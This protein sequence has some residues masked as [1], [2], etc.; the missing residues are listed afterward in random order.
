MC[1]IV[2][3]LFL[4]WVLRDWAAASSGAGVNPRN[5]ASL[6]DLT[7]EVDLVRVSSCAY[8]RRICSPQA[9]GVLC[10]GAIF[11]VRAHLALLPSV[12]MKHTSILVVAA[13]CLVATGMVAQHLLG[14]HFDWP[15]IGD[16][17]ERANGADLIAEVEQE[18]HDDHI[19]LTPQAVDN[20]QLYVAPL[21]RSD[22]QRWLRIPGEIV[23]QPGHS[24]RVLAAPVH[25]IVDRVSALPGMAIGAGDPLFELQVVD[26][27]I[28]DAQIELLDSI[29]RLEI[30]GAELERLA[31]LASSGAVARRQKLDLEYEQKQLAAKRDLR[32]QELMA[33]GL[34]QRDIDEL[35]ATRRFLRKITVR[36]PDIGAHTDAHGL[37]EL[38]RADLHVISDAASAT[39]ESS[40]K[41]H[42]DRWTFTVERLLIAPGQTVDRGDGLCDLAHHSELYIQGQVFEGEVAAVLH[43]AEMQWPLS[44]EFGLAGREFRREDL[45]LRYVANH[46]D[47]ETQTFLFYLPLRN[48]VLNDSTDVSGRKFRS[49]RFKV[50]QR[51]QV[52]APIERR[53]DCLK[54]PTAAVVQDGPNAYVF[55]QCEGDE[56]ETRKIDDATF[57][58]A[59]ESPATGLS[60]NTPATAISSD[61]GH[62]GE[63]AIELEPIPVAI[64]QRDQNFVVIRDDGQLLAGD[65]VAMNSAYQLMLAFKAQSEEGG[66][67]HHHDH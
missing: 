5:A 21:V 17:G 53:T 30:V 22:F 24:A 32:I 34:D 62:D 12:P 14:R 19:G 20:L 38:D 54:L 16:D 61:D 4:R 40:E 31:P 2:G 35:V 47:P 45:Y 11:A 55:R 18:Q 7:C 48:E 42:D 25:G 10:K 3:A 59:D 63:F 33:R 60:A 56:E 50:G 8:A 51:V 65:L 44:A 49:W 23:E 67:H 39:P 41:P 28:F 27:Q 26:E 37:A 29:T 13:L 15:A 66:G 64:D 58:I 46:V 36:V 57:G 43:A 9:S 1:A 52:L 6:L